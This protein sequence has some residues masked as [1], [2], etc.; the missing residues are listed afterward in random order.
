MA[1]LI[2]RINQLVG[3]VKRNIRLDGKNL[4]IVGNN[5]AGK[6]IFLKTL[7]LHLK[8]IFMN[9]SV[10]LISDLQVNLK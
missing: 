7:D 8:E 5:G 4:I 6:T 9:Q 3:D 2:K 1:N 10:E